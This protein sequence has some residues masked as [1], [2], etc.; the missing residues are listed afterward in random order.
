MTPRRFIQQADVRGEPTPWT[1]S[2]W[3]CRPDLVA[4]ERLLLVRATMEPGQCHQFH[5]HPHREEILYILE[6]RAE[7]WVGEERRLLGPGEA[8]HIPAGMVHATYNPHAAPLVFLAI[9]GP[10]KLPEAIAADPDPVDVSHE[11]PWRDLRAGLPPCF[12]RPFPNG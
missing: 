12:T 1:I 2:E 9:L 8:A 6:G 10:A 5:H 7:Q 3:I 11:A 4:A